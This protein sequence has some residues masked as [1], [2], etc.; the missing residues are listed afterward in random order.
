[1]MGKNQHVVKRDDG[2]AVLGEGNSRDTSHHRTQQEAIDAARGIAINQQSE[3]L[4]HGENG[5]IRER[6]SYG[7]DPYPPK[8]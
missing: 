7:N 6:N 3:V 1:M 5:K 2:W 8:G 4:I